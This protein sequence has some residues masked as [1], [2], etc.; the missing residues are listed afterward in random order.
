VQ[1]TLAAQRIGASE[2]LIDQG[3]ANDAGVV[4]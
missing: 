3:A 4:G 1:D 2:D